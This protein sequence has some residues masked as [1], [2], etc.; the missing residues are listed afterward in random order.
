M[1]LLIC[2]GAAQARLKVIMLICS[3]SGSEM[4]LLICL[5]G[6]PHDFVNLFGPGLP[7]WALFNDFVNLS[8]GFVLRPGSLSLPF[9]HCPN[10][11]IW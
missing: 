1:I 10:L 5:A 11:W 9:P 3:G 4:L 7:K 2:S 6:R 8:G